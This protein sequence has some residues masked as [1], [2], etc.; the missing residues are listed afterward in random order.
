MAITA[1]VYW[2]ASTMTLS[3]PAPRSQIR[4]FSSF[5]IDRKANPKI[6]IRYLTREAFLFGVCRYE[7]DNFCGV[8]GNGHHRHWLRQNRQRH[9]FAG[10]HLVQGSRRGPLPAF[11]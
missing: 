2:T 5:T 4:R 10:D 1:L 9:S 6:G 7:E 8:C 11:R 3:A